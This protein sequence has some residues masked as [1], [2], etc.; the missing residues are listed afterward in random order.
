MGRDPLPEV[1]PILGHKGGLAHR[2]QQVWDAVVLDDGAGPQRTDEADAAAIPPG[3][4]LFEAH[5]LQLFIQNDHAARLMSACAARSIA[6]RTAATGKLYDS[7]TCSTVQ[8]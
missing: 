3:D 6:S 2:P 8:P 5:S 1:S 7:A 4:L